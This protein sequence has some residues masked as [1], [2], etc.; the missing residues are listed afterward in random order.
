M[1]NLKTSDAPVTSAVPV[2]AP[3]GR[4]DRIWA[5]LST[6]DRHVLLGHDREVLS[7]ADRVRLSR[8]VAALGRARREA[9]APSGVV[10]S[11]SGAGRERRGRR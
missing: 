9:G 5:G 4:L 6:A 11:R 8:V 7:A 10:R 1:T 3:S 2:A